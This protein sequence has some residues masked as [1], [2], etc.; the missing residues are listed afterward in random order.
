MKNNRRLLLCDHD[1]AAIQELQKELQ[2]RGYEAEV[3]RDATQ[4]IKRVR[5]YQPT[6]VLANPEIDGFNEYDVCKYVMK[7]MG[8]PVIL[9]L[10]PHSTTR[11]QI[12]ECRASDVAIKP[13]E[14]NNLSNLIEKHITITANKNI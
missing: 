3:L 1:E 5:S 4:L 8:L 2:N 7:E 11:A 13:V 6:V 12:D 9:L 10:E 14:I